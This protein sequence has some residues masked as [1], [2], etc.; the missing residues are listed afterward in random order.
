MT[1]NQQRSKTIIAK[2]AAGIVCFISLLVIVGWF[3]KNETLV[4]VLPVYVVMVFN[5]ALSILVLGVALFFLTTKFVWTTRVLVIFVGVL[6]FF[7]GAQ[8]LLDVNFGI[9]ELFHSYNLDAPMVN[10]G[11]MSMN[12]AV[13]LVVLSVAIFLLTFPKFPAPNTVSLI[14]GCI[15][16]AFPSVSLFGYFTGL[17][18]AAGWSTYSRMAVHTAFCCLIIAIAV[19][20]WAVIETLNT[21]YKFFTL[22]FSVSLLVLVGGLGVWQ[23]M[24]SRDFI[25]A[26][27]IARKQAKATVE[28]VDNLLRED[29]EALNRMAQRWATLG[30]YNEALWKIDGGNYINDL[31][32]LENILITDA[33]LSII[34]RAVPEKFRGFEF[35]NSYQNQ[36]SE[37]KTGKIAFDYTKTTNQLLVFIPL[38]HQKA[39]TGVLLAF[40]DIEQIFQMAIRELALENT[41][42][43]IIINYKNSVVFLGNDPNSK[44]VG[45]SI[46]ETVADNFIPFDIQFYLTEK[47]L[48]EES[49]GIGWFILFSGFVTMGLG[50]VVI[51]ISLKMA[52]KKKILEEM[53]ENLIFAREKADQATIAKSAFLATMSH[54]I[55]T[56]LNAVIGSIQLL[57][58][59]QIDDM[60]KKYIK[61]IDFSSKAL[62]SLIN[63]ILDYS[64]IEAGSL[65]FDNQPCDIIQLFE[66][67]C[68]GFAPK[69]EEKKIPL[70]LECPEQPIPHLVV[71][72]HRLQQIIANLLTNAYKFTEKGEVVLRSTYQQKDESNGLLHVEISDSGIGISPENQNKLFQKFSQVEVSHARKQGGVGLGLS[73]CKSLIEKMEGSVGVNSVEGQGTTFWFEVSLPIAQ[74]NE[75]V[76]PYNLS[77]K[78][79]LLADSNPKEKAIIEKYLKA[80][81][82]EVLGEGST[83]DIAIVSADQTELIQKL[84]QQNSKI[85][86]IQRMGITPVEG[87]VVLSTPITPKK[88][89]ETLKKT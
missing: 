33:N 85:V 57:A 64:K 74:N 6:C 88:L 73:I 9:D 18:E 15:V 47:S 68:E 1:F 54:E 59:T 75:Q 30:G 38:I 82:A 81:Q 16:I 87:Q 60:Q 5:T 39:F 63:D 56:P 45:I 44:A 12:T 21:K 86:Y 7:S 26:Q 32:A 71:D 28:L 34:K 50:A 83:F 17:E 14:L 55:R 46:D 19:A 77:Q 66:D 4:R 23:A 49:S 80:W 58:E 22:P 62:L 48:A 24:Y 42:Y 52:D 69:S 31:P 79:I 40:I 76:A 25:S 2:I 53:N 51:Y 29:V 27:T 35:H 72:S 41:N 89:F 37:T 61:R 65:K 10:P 3:L 13:S 84:Q 70:F 78:K 20:Y 8:Y 43:Q 11:R 67:I 36:I